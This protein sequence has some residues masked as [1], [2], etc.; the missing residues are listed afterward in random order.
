MRSLGALLWGVLLGGAAVLL[1]AAFVP[2]G[3]LLSLLGSATGIWLVGRHLGSRQF[4]VLAAI[5]WISVAFVAATQGV[6]GE[7]L[8]A[9]NFA[10]NGL[11]VGGFLVLLASTLT[12]A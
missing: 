6:G 9:A 7:Y 8:V 4:K 1:H 11:L 12:R 10:G 3:L 5:G 2:F